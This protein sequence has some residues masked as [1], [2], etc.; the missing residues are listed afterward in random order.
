[1]QETLFDSLILLF[2]SKKEIQFLSSL[3][4]LH[5][6]E[7][8]NWKDIKGYPKNEKYIAFVDNKS[9]IDDFSKI[10]YDPLII[11][12]IPDNLIEDYK[13]FYSKY[14]N[15]EKFH[16]KNLPLFSLYPSKKRRDALISTKDDIFNE[17]LKMILKE[18]GFNTKIA[19][20]ES[21]ILI[22]LENSNIDLLIINFDDFSP[23]ENL[24]SKF[25]TNPFYKN[26]YIRLGIQ[27]FKTDSILQRLN[28]LKEICNVF[29]L[30]NELKENFIHS[31]GSQL[32]SSIFITNVKSKKDV[33]LWKKNLNGK[34]TDLEVDVFDF[35][36]F[37]ELEKKEEI[38][39]VKRIFEWII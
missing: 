30:K 37:D 15:L 34:Y 29:F 16:L 10:F 28:E 12:R 2:M 7:M 36:L 31:I 6:L 33:F 26:S 19:K 24:V 17:H 9:E 25:Q 18:N 38:I 5:D 20:L 32:I 23:L 4:N 22:H 39:K 35:S 3:L 11:G 13:L 21:E 8:I 27:D 1:M 14:Y